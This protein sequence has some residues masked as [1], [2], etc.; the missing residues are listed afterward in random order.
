MQKTDWSHTKAEGRSVLRSELCP[1]AVWRSSLRTWRRSRASRLFKS[2]LTLSNSELLRCPQT[3]G[4]LRWQDFNVDVTVDVG[5]KSDWFSCFVMETFS[6]QCHTDVAQLTAPRWTCIDSTL[7]KNTL[8]VA[9]TPISVYQS[10][11]PL[12]P[13][14]LSDNHSTVGHPHL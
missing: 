2:T 3:M 5:L 12:W 8:A 14:L 7:F 10:D 9:S 13:S 1:V 6:L 11:N 4:Y